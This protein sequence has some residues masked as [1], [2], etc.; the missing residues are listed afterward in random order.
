[1][2]ENGSRCGTRTQKPV[3]EGT[4]YDGEFVAQGFFLMPKK[5]EK[6]EIE[7][8]RAPD[9]NSAEKAWTNRGGNSDFKGKD[10]G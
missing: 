5:S 2:N 6:E 7:P 9:T 10:A 8:E 4:V 1:M 3:T